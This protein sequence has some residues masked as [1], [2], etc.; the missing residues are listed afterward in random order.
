MKSYML[1]FKGASKVPA[2]VEKRINDV[3]K[4]GGLKAAN[5]CESQ[6]GRLYVTLYVDENAKTKVECKM[7]RNHVLEHLQDEINGFL[8]EKIKMRI[9]HQL[10]STQSNN[11]IALMFFEKIDEKTTTEETNP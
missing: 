6:G 2:N 1:D 3:L 8:T 11:M 5:V 10:V 7:F 4:K 9:C